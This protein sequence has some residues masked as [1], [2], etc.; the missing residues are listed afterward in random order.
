[1]IKIIPSFLFFPIRATCPAHFIL[2]DFMTLI[3]FGD[4]RKLCN[5][6][7]SFLH[8]LRHRFRCSALNISFSNTSIYVLVGWE[9]RFCT[10]SKIY[11][12]LF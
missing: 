2:F 1:M 10:Q 4:E 9:T 3:I 8:F 11:F 7:S 12:F 6:S 5:C